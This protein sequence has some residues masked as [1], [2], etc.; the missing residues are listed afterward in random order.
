MMDDKQIHKEMAMEDML[1]W[2]EDGVFVVL[3]KPGW[4]PRKQMID[5]LKWNIEQAEKGGA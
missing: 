2:L 3:H 1:E 4:M 5:L